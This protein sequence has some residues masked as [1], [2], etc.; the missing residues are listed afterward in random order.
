MNN[1]KE[2]S[3]EEKYITLGQFAKLAYGWSGGEAKMLIQEGN[4]QV[5]GVV[6]T[7]RSRKLSGGDVVE[8]GGF[9][10]YRLLTSDTSSER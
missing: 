5:N 2:I 9:G 10:A 6:E 4:V 7:R 3:I 8:A 1:I